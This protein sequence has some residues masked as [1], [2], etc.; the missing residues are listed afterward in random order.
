MRYVDGRDDDFHVQVCEDNQFSYDFVTSVS[1]SFSFG[2]ILRQACEL[3]QLIVN[4]LL[5]SSW[6]ILMLV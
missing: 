2:C 4:E 6:I 1:M 5:D 3:C